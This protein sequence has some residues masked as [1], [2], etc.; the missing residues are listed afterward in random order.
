[1][2]AQVDFD[3]IP[4]LFTRLCDRY[5]GQERTILRYKERGE[6]WIDI[7]WESLRDRVESLAGFLHREGV[8]KGDRVALLSENRP[9]W[10]MTDLATQ[11]I[12]GVNVSIYTS[13]PPAK[14]AYILRDS[15]AKFVVVSVP[16]QR[17]KVEEIM[18]ECPDL[19]GVIVMSDLPDDPPSN[20]THWD[21]ALEV[22]RTYWTENAAELEPIAE[23]VQP[24]DTSALI[25][26]SGTTGEPKGVVLTNRNFCSNVKAALKVVPF[27]EDD[28][29]LSFLPLCHAFERTAGYTAVMSAGATIS[30]A[31]SIEA[32]SQN[33]QEVNPTVM[34]S[35]PRMFEKMYNL[36]SKQATSGSAIKEKVFN[37]AVS[38]GRKYAEAAD[39]G[40]AGPLLKAQRAMA[41][42]FVFSKLHEKLG[43]NLKFAVSGGAALP[44]EIGK[45][46]QAAGVT[47]IEGYGLTETAPVMAVNPLDAPRYGTVGHILPGVTVAIQDIEDGSIIGQVS[48]DDYPTD[49]TTREGEI[50]TKGP[51]VM[52]QYWKLPEETR[53][54]FDPEGWYHTGD[55]GKFDDGYLQITD[56]IKH[57]IVSRG[58][59]NIYPG[60]LEDEFK[61]LAWVD[62]IMIVG[63]DRPFLTALVVPDFE[64]LRMAARDQGIDESKY[65]NDEL[66]EMDGVRKLFDQAFRKYNRDAAAHEKIRNFHLIAE[67]FTVEDGALTPTLKLKRRV[68]VARYDEEIDAM[69]AKFER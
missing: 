41:N 43:G 13:L 32:V 33:L 6:G 31:E 21:D 37:W 52:K 27:D 55:V 53:A 4:Q 2:P 62:Q 15:G 29:H 22:G 44:K 61:T 49:L 51:N 25:Y 10:A 36:V 34:I 17:K 64:S 38:A 3:T 23:S 50:V 16:V 57:M 67:P 5:D 48:G 35:V 30:Y 11:L 63:E 7:S 42:R 26:T 68:I 9:E 65:T 20:M 66:I 47:I 54:A 12:G 58:G 24:D 40:N 39:N 14:V 59:K 18:D 69:Y 46:F 8:R 1:M 60:P 19:E 56:R 45:F 28:H